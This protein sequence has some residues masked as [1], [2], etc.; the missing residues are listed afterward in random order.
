MKYIVFLFAFAFSSQLKA[1]NNIAKPVNKIFVRLYS[2]SNKKIARGYLQYGNDSTIQVSRN[3]T[4]KNFP[5]TDIGVIKT[6]HATGHNLLIG[7]VTGAVA[8]AAAIGLSDAV[9][10]GN[11]NGASAFDIAIVG[12]L[13]PAAGVAGGGIA[14]LLHKS[15]AY[16]INSDRTKWMN[17]R[18][19]LLMMK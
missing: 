12:L 1:Q 16:M 3:H 8:G 15:S 4:V 14:E 2:N 11:D 9:R 5:V 7:T 18:N 13:L 17:A 19:E 10:N 6:K